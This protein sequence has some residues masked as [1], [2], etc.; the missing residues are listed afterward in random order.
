MAGER[1]EDEF[2]DVSV[3]DLLEASRGQ[4]LG[5]SFPVNS[6]EGSAWAFDHPSQDSDVDSQEL[7]DEQVW[8]WFSYC[9]IAVSTTRPSLLPFRVQV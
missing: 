4:R 3:D 8:P 9:F 2:S 1:F 7:L 6:N 5:E